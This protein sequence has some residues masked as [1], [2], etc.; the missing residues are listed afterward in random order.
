MRETNGETM[1]GETLEERFQQLMDEIDTAPP[2]VP[3]V[4]LLK[5]EEVGRVLRVHSI[6][7]R[8]LCDNG[9]IPD[10]FKVGGQWRIPVTSFQKY[11]QK[12]QAS[13]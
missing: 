2:R 8:R 3:K 13:A 9:T 12:L 4:R 5:P 1:N 10:A 7:V 6:T 11:L